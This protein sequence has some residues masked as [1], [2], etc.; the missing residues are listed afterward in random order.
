MERARHQSIRLLHSRAWMGSMTIP[1][2]E[3][4]PEV[5]SVS[6]QLN[7]HEGNKKLTGLQRHTWQGCMAHTELL[8]FLPA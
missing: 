6:D 2:P 8:Q 7:Q 3:T 1:G 4:L 5:L